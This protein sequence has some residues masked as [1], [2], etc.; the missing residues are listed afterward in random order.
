MSACN[1]PLSDRVTLVRSMVFRDLIEGQVTTR[2]GYFCAEHQQF[3]EWVVER[4]TPKIPLA[5]L[6]CHYLNIPDHEL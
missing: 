4:A 1:H 2:L 6:D 3:G 5:S